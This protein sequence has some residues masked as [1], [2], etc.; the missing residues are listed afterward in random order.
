MATRKTD[1]VGAKS[2]ETIEIAYVKLAGSDA[3]LQE[4]S[5]PSSAHR[6][7]E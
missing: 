3:T 4:A 6:T 7:F 1:P 5:R 2:R